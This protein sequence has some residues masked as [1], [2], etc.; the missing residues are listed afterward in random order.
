MVY[1]DKYHQKGGSLPFHKIENYQNLA[2]LFNT[3]WGLMEILI[4]PE[5]KQLWNF[6]QNCKARIPNA[7]CP[8]SKEISNPQEIVNLI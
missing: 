1:G 4:V 7:M 3:L 8:E 5:P 2:G 6:I